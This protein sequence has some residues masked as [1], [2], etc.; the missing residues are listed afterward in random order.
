MLALAGYQIINKIIQTKEF[1]IIKANGLEP[2]E[3][4]GYENEIQYIIDHYKKFGNV[5]D[6]LTFTANFPEF[7][8]SEVQESDEY[9]VDQLH[10]QY[11]YQKF[12][13]F[14]P[15][16]NKKLKEDSRAAYE[17]MMQEAKNTLKPHTVC[18]GIDIIANAQE[19]YDIYA[20]RNQTQTVATISTGFKELDEI[21]GG[22]EYGDELV[23][24]VART[25][26][27]KSWIL[28]KFLTEAW[29]QG[30]TV[31]LYSGEMNHIKLGYRFDALFGHYSNRCLVR[32]AQVDGY[33]EYISNLP[34][35]PGKLIIATQE[36]FHGR[37]TVSKIRNFIE[38]NNIE[39]MGID[40]LSLMDDGR[41]SR[42]DPPRM[43]L[44]HI[45]EDLFLLSSE[46]K[47]PILAL[48]QANRAGIKNDENSMDAP[49]LENIKESDDIAHN[50]SKC[51]G[52]RQWN[53]HLIL[54]I[55]KNREGRVGDKLMYTW[56]I[57]TG[58]FTY[59]PT[60]NDAA[61]ATT[62]QTVATQAVASA[63]AD[64]TACPF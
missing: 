28:M 54:D 50:S 20:T 61:V 27:G 40:Q 25:N 34:N 16:F 55:I 62:R 23:T 11:G 30:K 7:E 2:K 39:I 58:H 13:D 59:I 56:D 41:A 53:G 14:L 17:F 51:I 5:P 33:Q 3:F 35:L 64:I 18:K 31:G 37:P 49:G 4:V 45:S 22:W 9:L 48:A 60:A 42:N 26:V 44:S 19:R 63:K 46:Y 10:E 47:I 24:I 6:G 21:F 15:E 8:Y 36:H 32:G 43:R 57:D 12:N 52:M 29:K 38:E 1:G